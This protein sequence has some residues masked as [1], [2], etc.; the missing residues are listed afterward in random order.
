[1]GTAVGAQSVFTGTAT[2]SADPSPW[3]VTPSPNWGA[4]N[5]LAAIACTS[6]ASCVAVGYYYT[7]EGV[8]QTLVE[9]LNDATWSIIPSPDEG[10]GNN[11]LSGVSCTSAA[12]CVAVGYYDG[13]A[14]QTLAESWNGITWSI[15]ASANFGTGSN[16]LSSV[17]CT[18][19]TDCVAVGGI[20]SVGQAFTLVE[21]STGSTW[22]I[23]SSGTA[24][25]DGF[26]TGV[27]CGSPT[28]CMAVGPSVSESSNGSAWSVDLTPTPGI[29]TT[30]NGVSCTSS[31]S[32]TAVGYAAS[33]AFGFF[34]TVVESWDGS[35]WSVVNSPDE[36]NGDSYLN[37][38]SCPSATSCT[39]V[40]YYH[41]ATSALERTLVE[42]W[43][44]SAWSL[45]V[46]PNEGTTDNALNGVSCTS[47]TSCTAAGYEIDY[48]L[49]LA[50]SLAESW[51]GSAWS[52]A[53]TPNLGLYDNGLSDVSC[54]SSTFCMAVGGFV[55]SGLEQTLSETWDG[56]SWSV[57]ASVNDGSRNNA[58][59]GVACTGPTSCVAVGSYA[60]SSGID[61]TLIESWD[62]TSWSIVA[63]PNPGT[64]G[65]YL[66]AVSCTSATRCVAVGYYFDESLLKN[67]TLIESWDGGSWSIVTSANQVNSANALFGVSCAGAGCIAVGVSVGGAETSQTLTESWNGAAWSITSSPDPGSGLLDE[68]GGVTCTSSTSCV[69]VGDY[70]NGS[71]V[72]QTLVES[73]NG[74]IWSLVSSPD[75]GSANNA[76][77]KVACTTAT[78][79]V[80]V[81][82]YFNGTDVQQTLVESWNGSIWSLVSS[83][84]HGSGTNA[85]YGVSSAGPANWVAVGGYDDTGTNQTLVVTYVP[86]VSTTSVLSVTAHPIIGQPITIDVSVAAPSTGSL[87]PTGQVTVSDGTQ[88]C[89]ATLVGSNG[90]A[91]GT[92]SI[93]EQAA[94]QYSLTASY[95]GDTVFASSSTA[96]S[97]AVT[98]S[99]ATSATVLKLSLAKV[100]FGDEQA[101]HFSVTVSPEF[102]G[103]PTGTVTVKD[104]KITL[105]SI[106]LSSGTGSCSAKARA[107]APGRYPL[108]ATYS[109]SGVFDTSASAAD[110]LTVAKASSK[111][112]LRVSKKTI[113][114]G[115]E[116][117]ERLSVTVS[118]QF[119]GSTPSGTVTVKESKTELCVIKLSSGKGSCTLSA[120]RLPA[121]KYQLTASYGGSAHFDTSTSA[122]E[123]VTVVK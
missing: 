37:A 17:T 78:N 54:T 101:D 93:T 76:L 8:E 9:S 118:P 12:S 94:G 107:L 95:P 61:D 49:L 52:L 104:S 40:G 97:T 73:W 39:A 119:T 43:N 92:C 72:D 87:T 26:L 99:K 66:N 24:N 79:C 102:T 56:T 85:L 29:D 111:T 103:T 67:E 116:Q 4:R 121:A 55:E 106:T 80:A 5:E 7:P 100:T 48:K 120:K 10:S 114:Y 46:S 58:L 64:Q 82:S 42:T 31:T 81:G 50:E 14:Q 32:C 113:T 19:S 1:M 108:V 53:S 18:S 77:G 38:V 11:V 65:S 22:S 2:A 69:A 86:L 84:N 45:A 28:T 13:T 74:S 105:C 57:L 117:A 33:V 63:S 89:K 27:S 96:S 123:T 59:S 60:N 75:E 20:V 47:S 109:G 34:Q 122:K 41:T 90:T 3:S 62:G 23:N 83:P 71:S 51:N 68:L 88:N 16:Y 110:T 30:I 112:A 15:V 35:T 25:A 36:G 98:V 70:E 21:T 6:S 44:G 115:D 91:S